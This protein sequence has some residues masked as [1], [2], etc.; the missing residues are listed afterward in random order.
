MAL[1]NGN[2]CDH[3]EYKHDICLLCGDCPE[4]RHKNCGECIEAHRVS[5]RRVVVQGDEGRHG[6]SAGTVPWWVHLKAWEAYDR[7]G[8]GEQ[9]AERIEERGGFGY[10][11]LQCLLADHYVCGSGEHGPVPGWEPR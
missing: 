3:D 5:Y 10:G 6:C 8:H 11:E 9:S 4:H 1:A 2:L 7:A